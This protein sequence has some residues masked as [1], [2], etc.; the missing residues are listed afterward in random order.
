MSL[1]YVD[2]D[3]AIIGVDANRCYV[4][5]KDGMMQYVPIETVDSITLLGKAQLT[6]GCIQE[7][8]NRGIPV[9]FFS[10]GGKYFGRLESTG[11][12]NVRHQRLQCS[13]YESNYSLELSKRIIKAKL[14]NQYVVLRRYERGKGIVESEF[15]KMIMICRNKIDQCSSIDELMGYE[16]Q[17]A[18]AYFA[19]VSTIINED[20]KFSGRNKRPPLDEFNSMI[21]LGYS[22]LMN[23]IYGKIESKG[24]NPYFGL[25]HKD[26]EKHPTLAS[27]LMEEW[28][29]VIVDTTVIG[30]INGHEIDK[31]D[32]Y[33]D[34]EDGG[35]YISKNGIKKYISKLENKLKS[36]MRYLSYIDYAVSFRKAMSLQINSLVNS[37]ANADA[38]LYSPLEIR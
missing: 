29:P 35:C 25:M 34:Y 12:I 26:H 28:R 14:K 24:L 23:E 37:M 10:K 13:L 18:K 17:G 1:L 30:M 15:S 38:S 32:F 8:L 11:H 33:L 36:E 7:C 27:D 6:T 2:E 5:Y 16:G 3:S 19:G 9:M 20:F 4:K 22:I 21:S 31:T